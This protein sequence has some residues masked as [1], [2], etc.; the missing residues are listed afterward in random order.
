MT[1][2]LRAGLAVAL[3]LASTWL[4]AC[5]SDAAPQPEPTLEEPGSF[6]AVQEKPGVFS[7]QRT[8]DRVVLETGTI[9]VFTVYDVTPTSWSAARAISMGHD[10]PILHETTA[11][12]EELFTQSDY[13]V[14]WFRTLTDEE[15]QRLK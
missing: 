6:V 2:M 9:L 12:A 7:L 3:A 5:A 14:V 10:I 15:E 8:L 1:P 11:L 13:R 4:P